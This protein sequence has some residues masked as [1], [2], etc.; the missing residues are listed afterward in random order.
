MTKQEFESI[1]T[2][3]KKGTYISMLWETVTTKGRKVSKGVVRFTNTEVKT[4]KQG[5]EYVVARIT[6]NNKQH[7]H[8]TYFNMQG[9]E[10]E[11]GEYEANNKTYNITDFF[12]KHLENIIQLG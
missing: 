10:I 8:T 6:K 3:Y 5:E 1:M 12:A 7:T 9:D 11:K 2:T 4:N